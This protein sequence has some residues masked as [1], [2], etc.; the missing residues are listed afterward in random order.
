MNITYRVDPH[1]QYTHVPDEILGDMVGTLPSWAGNPEFMHLDLHEAMEAQY[2]F[3]PLRHFDGSSIAEDGLYSYPEDPDMHPIFELHR[4]D[5]ILYIYEY[6][7]VAFVD[8][9]GKAFV[10]RMD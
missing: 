8:K 7:I 5:E 1:N 3:G 9:N 6:A 4:K 10:T 2:G